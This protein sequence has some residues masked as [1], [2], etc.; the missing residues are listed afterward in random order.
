MIVITD[1][2]GVLESFYW[3]DDLTPKWTIS[4]L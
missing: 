3:S 4:H 2:G 1:K